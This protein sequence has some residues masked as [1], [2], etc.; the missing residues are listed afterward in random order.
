MVHTYSR[1]HRVEFSLRLRGGAGRSARGSFE[2]WGMQ[3]LVPAI[4]NVLRDTG[5]N[6]SCPMQP[7]GLEGVAAAAWMS[8]MHDPYVTTGL[9]AAC[10]IQGRADSVVAACSPSGR[11][12]M[13]TPFASF[14][15]VIGAPQEGEG[16]HCCV[17]AW[18][19]TH[20]QCCTVCIRARAGSMQ[21]SFTGA[22][23]TELTPHTQCHGVW[24][25]A[26]HAPAATLR[27]AH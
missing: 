1:L 25:A 18:C 12:G 6:A 4:C 2:N 15:L 11:G 17:T 9:Q 26:S 19:K 24:H 10:H 21:G 13:P 14:F 16:L 23:D 7:Q 22:P 27:A 5:C 3:L 8:V 20:R